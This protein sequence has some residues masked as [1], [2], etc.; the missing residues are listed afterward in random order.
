MALRFCS[1]QHQKK[2]I[3][4]RLSPFIREQC[5][6]E[7]IKVSEDRPFKRDR[8]LLRLR[9]VTAEG[10]YCSLGY[11]HDEVHYAESRCHDTDSQYCTPRSDALLQIALHAC[12]REMKSRQSLSRHPSYRVGLFES[13]RCLPTTAGRSHEHAKVCLRNSRTF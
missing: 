4:S 8:D 11:N 7:S 2:K 1:I 5:G 10:S 3:R 6:Y 12:R 9:F 13:P